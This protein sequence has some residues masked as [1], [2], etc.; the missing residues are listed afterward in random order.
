MKTIA[1]FSALAL[2]VIT[3]AALADPTIPAK[4]ATGQQ[5]GR[6]ELSDAQM[7]TLKAGDRGNQDFR[8]N[9]HAQDSDLG[10]SSN[11]CYKKSGIHTWPSPC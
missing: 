7:D 3:S 6:V 1:L 11:A 4:T 5:A 8:S 9:G 10:Q 2:G